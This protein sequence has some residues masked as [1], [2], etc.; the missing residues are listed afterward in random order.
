ME[1]LDTTFRARHHNEFIGVAILAPYDL[2][3]LLIYPCTTNIYYVFDRRHFHVFLVKI[4]AR[5]SVKDKA[6]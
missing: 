6:F 5:S 4:K 1:F 3:Q 2:I